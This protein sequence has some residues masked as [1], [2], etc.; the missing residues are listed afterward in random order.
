MSIKNKFTRR[1]FLE[2]GLSGA[3][4]LMLA[5]KA[6][7]Q[8]NKKSKV[9]LLYIGTYTSSGKSEGIYVHKFDLE[10]GKLTPL[11]IVKDVLEPSFLTIDK[12]RKYLYAANELLE[13]E[14]KKSG[15]VSAFAIDQKTGNLQFLNKQSSLGDAPCFITTTENEK[16]ALV[17]NYLGGNVSVYPIEKNGKLGASVDLAQHTGFGPNTDRQKSAHAHSITLDRNNRFAFAAD[18]GIDKLM[19]YAFDAKTGKL[20]PNEKQPFYQTKAGAGPRHFSFHPN[21]KQAFLINE[22]DLTMTSLA[23]DEKIGTL[24]EIQI[25]STLPA[26]VSTVGATCADIH[27]S[28]NGKFLYGSNRGH[29]SIVS[30]KIHEKTGR[31]EYIEHTLTGGKKP[32]NFAIAP[33]GKFLLVA[34]Q[35]SDNIVV[36]RIDEK[37][38]KLQTTGNM[39]Q[40][41][42]PVCLKFIPSFA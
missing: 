23:Y 16:F 35:D 4:S 41:P 10:T 26:G 5:Q 40:V 38:G 21:G 12:S 6:F 31:L 11:H 14:G 25:V 39:A 34:N 24:K 33:D 32:R 37:T 36:F 20:K 27:V 8:T 19:I 18:L 3:A 13:Y 22:L 15:A 2:I 1:E 28:P 7:A 29:N 30:Y 42:V 17:A 9:M